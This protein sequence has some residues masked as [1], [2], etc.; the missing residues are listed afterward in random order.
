MQAPFFQNTG[1]DKTLDAVKGIGIILMVLGHAG[2]AFHD[3]IYLFHMA[4]FFMISGYLWSDK[5]VLDLPS[6]GRFLLS[7]LKGLLLPFFLCN[8]IFT[9]LQNPLNALHLN[10]EGTTDLSLGQTA[11]NFV[12][13]MLFAADTPLGGTTWFLRTLFFVYIAHGVIR[14]VVC[15]IKWGE[16]LFAVVALVTVAA[17]VYI[18]KTDLSLPMGIHTCFSAYCAFL[19]GWLLR[20]LSVMEKLQRFDIPI[21][22]GSFIILCLL[23][24]FGP[25]GIGAGSIV[26]LPVFVGASML[27]FLMTYCTA[28]CLKGWV[29][30]ALVYCGKHTLWIVALHFLAFKPVAL[31]YLLATGKEL[32]LLSSF[33]VY[34]SPWL[35]PLYTLAG[36]VLPLGIYQLIAKVKRTV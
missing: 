3:F 33:P 29:L 2:V 25:V 21:A 8:G 23:T 16:I 27:G 4:L 24:P 30:N 34:A 9:L 6:L 22:I 18:D 19:L 5:K 1:R 36:I 28:R 32:T 31:V 7:R 13:N 35:W 15:R 14:Y 10:P 11:V 17:T 20:R 26:N 12:K